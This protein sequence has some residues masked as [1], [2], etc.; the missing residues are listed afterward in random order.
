M[1]SY[2]IIGGMGSGKSTVARMLAQHGAAHLD[3]DAVGHHVLASG[4]VT[5][6]LVDAFGT[7]ILDDDGTVNRAALAH[8]A[9]KSQAS[10]TTLNNIMHPLIVREADALLQEHERTGAR[11]AIV[12]ISAYAGPGGAFDHLVQGARGIVAVAAPR[13]MRA[14][15]AI[16]QGYRKHDVLNR[17]RRQPT[18]R[19]RVQWATEVVP[20][21][22]SLKDLEKKVDELWAR[23]DNPER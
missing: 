1:D 14:R 17:L 20:N 22:R 13:S 18:E 8:G 4:L 19:E 16:K 7:A 9:F 11:I 5:D 2:I 15:R 6:A 12:E 10:T 21:V 3:L 23:L